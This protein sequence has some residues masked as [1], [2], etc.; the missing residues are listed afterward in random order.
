MDYEKMWKELRKILE[1]K[2]NMYNLK[3]QKNKTDKL[4]VPLC[5]AILDIMNIIESEEIKNN[6]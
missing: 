3:K 6:N 2:T 1:E 4:I 5:N